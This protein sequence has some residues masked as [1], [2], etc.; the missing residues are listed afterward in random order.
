[1]DIKQL[2]SF[3]AIVDYCNF[4]R[5]AAKLNISQASVSTH[6][7]QLEKELGVTL[8]NRNTKTVEVTDSGWVVYKYAG[9]I[10]EMER[11]VMDICSAGSRRIIRVGASAIPAAYILP[12]VAGQYGEL[13]SNDLLKISQC[14]GRDVV[15]G[16]QEGR[17]DVGLVDHC[18]E[19]EGLRCVPF[20][21]NPVVLITPA[22]ERYRQMQQHENA[23]QELLRDPIILR[24]D[25]ALEKMGLDEQDLQ[26]V[27][28]VEDLE[29][30]KNMVAGGMGVSVISEIAARDFLRSRRLLKF[31]LSGYQDG[32][33]LYLVY[34]KA[35][36]TKDAAWNFIDYLLESRGQ[37]SAPEYL[38]A[39]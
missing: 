26:V 6:L 28:R 17:F 29:T 31:D 36:S 7:L 4:S 39:R 34:P 1:M 16:V 22:T 20:Y 27:A 3:V 19:W 12:D 10:L 38:S 25:G 8:L 9:Q 24:E 18:G 5:A 35:C 2:R 21:P 33:S 37:I 13:F 32:G 30:V 14:S 11:C 23:V 15:T